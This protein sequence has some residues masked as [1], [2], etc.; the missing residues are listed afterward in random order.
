MTENQKNKIKWLNRAFHAEKKLTALYHHKERDKERAQ[1]ITSVLGGNIKGK[2]DSRENAVEKA[3]ITFA[4]STEEYERFLDDYIL[5]RSEIRESIE[6]L[7]DDEIEAIFIYRYLE[8]MTIEGIAEEMHYDERTIR[9]KHRSGI[10]KL[11][12]NVR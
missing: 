5:I 9:R 10:E 4:G 3:L 8:Y 1:C 2:S 11:S 7:H 6:S 12:G